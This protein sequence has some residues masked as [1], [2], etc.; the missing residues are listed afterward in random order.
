[1][2]SY[3]QHKTWF[4]DI[5]V[6]VIGGG[7]VGLSAAIH[8]KLQKPSLRISV[9]EKGGIPA[10]ATTRNA[11][12]AT[13]GSVSELA[14]DIEKHTPEQVYR[15]AANR[16]R[17]LQKLRALLGDEKLRYTP[18]NG[19]ELFKD[20][21]DI[22]PYLSMIEP[23][24]TALEEYIG[25]K[26]VFVISPKRATD[27][28][29]KNIYPTLIANRYEG[30]LHSGALSQAF[31]Q[32]ARECGVEVFFG[33]DID[34]VET[35]DTGVKIRF[36]QPEMSLQVKKV[37]ACTNGFS[38]HFFPTLDVQPARGLVLVTEPIPDLKIEGTFHHNKGFDY[39]RNIDG[40]I[41]LGGG[42]NLDVA[43]ETDTAEIVNP[44]IMEYLR[45]LLHETILPEN[46]ATISHIWTGVMG[47][48]NAKFPIIKE[49]D[50]NIYCAVR[51][52]GMGVALG[53]QTGS[54]AADMIVN[55][56]S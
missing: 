33:F 37:L 21:S 32:K 19:Y 39:F 43:T 14:D 7:I 27:F 30:M 38:R 46:D 31:I 12:F 4:N 13:F 53:T 36:G 44:K 52:G 22:T 42:R 15:L 55:S 35:S 40:R 41:L 50:P 25:L 24:N 2:L 16:Y 29:M 51:M 47:V 49:Y 6:A 11:G 54:D 8:L 34:T 5:D 10:G 9:F 48:G 56:L 3:W 1:M 23:L 17:G 45:Q 26:N 28:G 18:C 20:E